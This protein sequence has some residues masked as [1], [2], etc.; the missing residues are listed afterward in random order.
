MSDVLIGPPNDAAPG[1]TGPPD[2]RSPGEVQAANDQAEEYYNAM[3]RY[4]DVAPPSPEVQIDLNKLISQGIGAVQTIGVAAARAATPVPPLLTL[5]SIPAPAKAPAA[6]S[7]AAA[8][9]AAP[10]VPMTPA[11]PAAPL[12]DAAPAPLPQYQDPAPPAAKGSNTLLYVGGGTAAAAVLL[13]VVL[14]LSSSS[15]PAGAVSRGR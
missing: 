15:S 5:P 10:P 13:V 4:N 7:P 14:A 9:P 8:P 3:G 6:P 11:P 12:P 1:F 2:L